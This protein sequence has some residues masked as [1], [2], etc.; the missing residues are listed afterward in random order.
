[1]GDVGVS[2]RFDLRVKAKPRTDIRIRI[3][4]RAIRTRKDE[5]RIRPTIRRTAE[6]NATFGFA[7]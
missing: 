2:R 3:R 1:M 5:A 7:A 6:K 4:S